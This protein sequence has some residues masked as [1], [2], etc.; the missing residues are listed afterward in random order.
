M[1]TGVAGEG[2]YVLEMLGEDM[3]TNA[4]LLE[5]HE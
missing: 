5:Y 3:L 1:V 4:V 2:A